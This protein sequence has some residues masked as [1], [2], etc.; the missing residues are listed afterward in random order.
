[1]K[2]LKN[3]NSDVLE[4]L[5]CSQDEEVRYLATRFNVTPQAVKAAVRACCN[6]SVEH[7]IYYIQNIYLPLKNRN[8]N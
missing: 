8:V 7:L 6:N 1:M 3:E 4:F 2:S 5:D